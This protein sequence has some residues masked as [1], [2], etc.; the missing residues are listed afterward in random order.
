MSDP[1]G[2]WRVRRP[3]MLIRAPTACEAVQIKGLLAGIAGVEDVSVQAGQRRL[4]VCY[5]LLH[6][7]YGSLLK[8]LAAAEVGVDAGLVQR[9]RS[10]LYRVL[11][12]NGRDNA[13][14]PEG[15]CCNRPPR[16]PR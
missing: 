8:A 13:A 5:N 1:E 10:A 12:A 11:D 6:C 15:A 16:R 7:Q 4:R 9:F 2:D 3:V 14:E